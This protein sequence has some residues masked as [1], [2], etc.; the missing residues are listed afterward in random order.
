MEVVV[1]VVVID[2]K[3]LSQVKSVNCSGLCFFY[4][5]VVVDDVGQIVCFICVIGS[6]CRC[7]LI[8]GYNDC[9]LKCVVRKLMNE[10]IFVDM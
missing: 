9:F 4:C 2:V 5:F 1:I 3:L 10:C 7:V 6:M 8:D